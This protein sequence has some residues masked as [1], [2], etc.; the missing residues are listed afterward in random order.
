MVRFQHPL[1]GVPAEALLDDEDV[2][3]IA[4]ELRPQKKRVLAQ[5]RLESGRPTTLF[6]LQC[7]Q[8]YILRGGAENWPRMD[9]V[10]TAV[11]ILIQQEKEEAEK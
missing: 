4:D 6:M 1:V 8:R 10:A 3:A 9:A 2:V 7:T 5:C 11:L